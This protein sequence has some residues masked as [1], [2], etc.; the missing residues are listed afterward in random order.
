MNTIVSFTSY[1]ARIKTAELVAKSMLRQTYKPDLVVLYLSDKQFP[2]R[3]IP[4]SLAAMVGKDFQVR[5]TGDDQRSYKK[6]IPALSDFPNDII[7]TVDDDV[8]Y[9]PN[10]ISRLMRAHE[11]YPG[12]IIAH[13]GKIIS[14]APYK[15]WKLLRLNTGAASANRIATGCGG[16]L[17]P[18]HVLHSDVLR[19][20]I[21]MDISPTTDDLWFWAMTALNGKKIRVL[22][23]PHIFPHN[24]GAA[25]KTSLKHVNFKRGTDGNDIALAKIFARYPSL[26][27]FRRGRK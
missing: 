8:R 12:D 4:A 9:L 1:P 26:L 10:T 19:D 15:K 27:E 14:D 24:I 23:N 20:D 22:S 13:R 3:Q 6:L 2:N 5:W 16:I 18:P 7:I 11:K 25:Q 17:Y 21:Y